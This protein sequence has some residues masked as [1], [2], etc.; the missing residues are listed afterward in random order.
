[1]DASSLTNTSHLTRSSDY[2]RSITS[3]ISAGLRPKAPSQL[4]EQPGIASEID[5]YALL[6]LILDIYERD[7]LHDNCL[8]LSSVVSVNFWQIPII[9][10]G[11][12]FIVRDGF[13]DL[14]GGSLYSSRKT[15]KYVTEGKFKLPRAVTKHLRLSGDSESVANRQKTIDH[16]CLELRALTHHPLKMHQNIVD[17]LGLM[18][19]LNDDQVLPVLLVEKADYLRTP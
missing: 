16:V 14:P 10:E 7:R 17:F 2:P 11:K 6:K 19:E 5:L 13:S 12:N 1:M 9:G 8:V 18:W 4:Q 15:V 3:T